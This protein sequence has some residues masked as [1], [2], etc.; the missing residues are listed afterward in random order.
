MNSASFTNTAGNST[1]TIDGNTGINEGNLKVTNVSDGVAYKDAVNVSQLKQLADKVDTNKDN[2]AT[3]TANIAK[4][5]EAIGR[6]ISLGGNRG[7]SAE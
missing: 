4:N 6:K 7:S 1:V 2:I 3:N 5:T